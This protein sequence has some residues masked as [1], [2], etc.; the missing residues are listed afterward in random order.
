MAESP[1]SRPAWGLVVAVALSAL[2]FAFLWPVSDG[3]LWQQIIWTAL[4]A[5]VD[6][7]A[8]T[9]FPVVLV[10]SLLKSRAQRQR[11]FEALGDDN[12]V[13][14][15]PDGP[16]K[17]HEYLSAVTSTEARIGLLQ[18]SEPW[19]GDAPPEPGQEISSRTAQ[20]LGTNL[21]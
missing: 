2:W 7:A 3:P 8:F 14:G 9:V 4:R 16:R 21:K 17:L 20:D 10:M 19:P 6:V 18:R 13:V 12:T 15:D 11:E 5:T 1:R